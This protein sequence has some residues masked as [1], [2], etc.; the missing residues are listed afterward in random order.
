MHNG[1]TCRYLPLHTSVDILPMHS[2]VDIYLCLQFQIFPYAYTCRYFPMQ[3]PVD[4]SL[5]IYLQIFTY[6]DTCRYLPMQTPVDISLCIHLQIFTYAYT[7]RYFPM[8]TPVDISLC[9][10]LQI[11]TYG[12]IQCQLLVHL[13][14]APCVEFADL[15]VVHHRNRV[16]LAN[17]TLGCPLN[18]LWGC[19]GLIYILGWVALQHR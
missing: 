8:Q 1:D 14:H 9:R 18:T 4:I 10:H 19:P 17:D 7:C 12:G 2:S 6:V 16:V 13:L 3:T 11:F 15:G 5:C